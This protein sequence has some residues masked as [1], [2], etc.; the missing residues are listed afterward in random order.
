MEQF[1]QLMATIALTLG[2]SWASGINSYAAIGTLGILGATGQVELPETLAV[3]EHP[4]VIAAAVLM[5]T[6]EFF[7]DKF[8]GV[9]TAW[10]AVHTFIRI[11]AGAVLAAG[12]VGDLPTGVVIACGLVGG[13]VAGATHATKAGTRVMINASPEPVTNSIASVSEDAAVFGGLWLMWSHPW[14]FLILFVLFA[15]VVAW[16]LPKIWRGIRR[17]FAAAGRLLGIGKLKTVVV[18]PPE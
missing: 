18:S 15:A 16:V 3:L 8:P 2:A 9:D 11:P 17:V 10:D 6:V 5:Y 4:L 14:V 13:G 7:A 1:D 12:A